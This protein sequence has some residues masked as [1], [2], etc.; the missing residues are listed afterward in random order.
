[1]VRWLPRRPR[2]DRNGADRIGRRPIDDLGADSEVDERV[3]RP[4]RHAINAG[5]LEKYAGFLAEH[6]F[7][8]TKL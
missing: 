6:L 3:V 1:M 2:H 7:V 8:V 5:R 4:I